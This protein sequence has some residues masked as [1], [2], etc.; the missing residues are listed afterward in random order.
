M[1]SLPDSFVPCNG[2]Y[3][4]RAAATQDSEAV[5]GGRI[6]MWS[7]VS[8]E[9][10]S[11]LHDK[12]GNA[13]VTLTPNRPPTKKPD[14]ASEAEAK[15]F[16][17]ASAQSPEWWEDM[18]NSTANA[19]SSLLLDGGNVPRVVCTAAGRTT[20]LVVD[21]A[22]TTLISPGRREAVVDGEAAADSTSRRRDTK[23]ELVAAQ[24]GSIISG[25]QGSSIHL[26]MRRANEILLGTPATATAE[27]DDGLSPR[28]SRH[29]AQNEDDTP[30]SLH[31]KIT[32]DGNE[33]ATMPLKALTVEGVLL[34]LPG[35]EGTF[36]VSI[37]LLDLN[38]ATIGGSAEGARCLAETMV[39]LEIFSAETQTVR[40]RSSSET[41]VQ[42]RSSPDV[43]KM[44]VNGN[45]EGAIEEG[46]NKIE[47]GAGFNVDTKR[48]VF[49]V[50]LQGVDGY[51]LS[52]LHLIKHLPEKFRASALDLSCASEKYLLCCVSVVSFLTSNEEEGPYHRHTQYL[53]PGEYNSFGSC[54]FHRSPEIISKML[55]PTVYQYMLPL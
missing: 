37:C 4:V 3:R 34:T 42:V 49:V 33:M 51:K 30:M 53:K 25:T 16:Y 23:F 44:M 8:D 43:M 50:D 15:Q 7:H 45:M 20:R 22:T 38:P 12:A 41:T 40:R 5:R 18:V 11:L 47:A 2:P 26:R 35:L 36:S 39:L 48:V 21:L 27:V 29:L 10:C 9:R 54:V 6:S 1:S 14:R 32:A 19:E 28:D 46:N 24:D 31:V 55:S 13:V 17:G 52:T